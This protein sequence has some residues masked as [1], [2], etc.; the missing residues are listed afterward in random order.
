M[1]LAV[2]T[3]E[4]PLFTKL[5]FFILCVGRKPM[6]TPDITWF[7]SSRWCKTTKSGA[8][9]TCTRCD[10]NSTVSPRAKKFL[11]MVFKY[12]G[13]NIKSLAFQACG[14]KWVGRPVGRNRSRKMFTGKSHMQT[15]HRM[16]MVRAPFFL[17]ET[18]IFSEKSS[19]DSSSSPS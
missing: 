12:E 8:V 4:V 1:P 16:E 14:V 3:I 5:A 11:L 6:V 15:P 7:Q 19:L 9:C 18:C 17:C 13:P 2:G 10:E